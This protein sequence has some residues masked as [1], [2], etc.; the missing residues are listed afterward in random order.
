MA[1]SSKWNP[2]AMLLST[3]DHQAQQYNL[4]ALRNGILQ[5]M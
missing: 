5:K 1:N 3:K 2:L 4:Q